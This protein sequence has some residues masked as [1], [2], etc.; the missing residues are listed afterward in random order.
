MIDKNSFS[1]DGKSSLSQ[2]YPKVAL[3]AAVMFLILLTALHFIEPELDPSKHMISEY[4]LGPYGWL[5]SLAFFSLGIS[6]LAIALSTGHYAITTGSIIGRWLFLII[7]VAL[8]GV[9]I[10]YPYT[11]PSIASNLHTLCGL[12]VIFAFPA[13]AALYRKG[14]P[15]SE[16]WK[17]SDRLLQ[18]A[19]WFV[20]FGFFV[21]FAYVIVFHPVS[22][23]DNTKLIVGWQNRFMMLTYTVWLMVV[24]S[25][26]MGIMRT[27][28]TF[29]VP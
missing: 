26:A 29:R 10:F 11:Q 15:H 4:E 1:P 9:A 12:I 17:A 24:S 20:W 28:I 21:F 14:L 8:F 27:R 23:E 19:T 16:E 6:V 25:K 13:A 18:V 5:M 7:S 2:Y 22:A 3:I